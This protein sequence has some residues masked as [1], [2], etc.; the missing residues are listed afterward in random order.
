MCRLNFRA[1]LL[2]LVIVTISEKFIWA[3]NYYQP[4]TGRK[5]TVTFGDSFHNYLPKS[6]I[7]IGVLIKNN[8]S[9][10]VKVSQEFVIIDTARMKVWKTICLLY[11]SPSPRD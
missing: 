6:S 7:R 5:Y 8:S 4:D 3:A 11:T 10:I 2:I 1:L 9:E